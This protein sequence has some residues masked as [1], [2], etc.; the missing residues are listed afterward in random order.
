MKSIQHRIAAI[1]GAEMEKGWIFLKPNL[2][3]NHI[4]ARGQRNLCTDNADCLLAVVKCT[5]VMCRVAHYKDV[6]TEFSCSSPDPRLGKMPHKTK[7]KTPG[8]GILE[9]GYGES[10][11]KFLSAQFGFSIHNYS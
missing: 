3:T 1:E 5:P 2:Q 8:L 10:D 11:D 4:W 6:V 9:K 7:T